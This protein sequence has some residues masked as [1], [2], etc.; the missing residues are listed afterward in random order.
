MEKTLDISQQHAASSEAQGNVF[1]RVFFVRLMGQWAFS[2]G[3]VDPY[4]ENLTLLNTL[5]SCLLQISDIV[6]EPLQPQV[7]NTFSKFISYES[8]ITA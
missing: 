2:S 1:N 4:A 8:N 6:H 7:E 3:I 5:L